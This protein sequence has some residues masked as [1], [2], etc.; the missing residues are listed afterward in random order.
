[1]AARDIEEGEQLTISYC[2]Q[3]APRA[4][5]QQH[6]RFSYGFSCNCSLCQLEQREEEEAGTGSCP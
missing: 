5:R 4:T 2:D 3:T 6:L 1:M